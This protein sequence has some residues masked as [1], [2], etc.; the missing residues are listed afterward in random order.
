MLVR[1]FTGHANNLMFMIFH[2]TFWTEIKWNKK[3]P[4]YTWKSLGS[5]VGFAIFFSK[6]RRYEY[7]QKQ[8]KEKPFFTSQ[9]CDHIHQWCKG[10]VEFPIHWL[11]LSSI[12]SCVSYFLNSEVLLEIPLLKRCLCRILFKLYCAL[13]HIWKLNVTIHYVYP[14]V[15]RKKAREWAQVSKIQNGLV[16]RSCSSFLC[17]CQPHTNVEYIENLFQNIILILN[18]YKKW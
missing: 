3:K 12:S 15:I 6:S 10:S 1:V 2:H 17:A 5:C 9:W 16:G 13:R 18:K 11:Q 7:H 8:T 14:P 4:I